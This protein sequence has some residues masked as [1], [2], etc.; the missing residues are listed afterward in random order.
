MSKKMVLS[1]IL[2]CFLVDCKFATMMFCANCFS[3]FVNDELS[4]CPH[5]VDK[6]TLGHE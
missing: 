4:A 2:L 6:I 1:S 3:I 5:D